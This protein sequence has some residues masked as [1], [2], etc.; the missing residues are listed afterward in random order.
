MLGLDNQRVRAGPGAKVLLTVEPGAAN[1]SC[2]VVL[3]P[4][5]DLLSL[6]VMNQR[7]RSMD[8]GFTGKVAVVTGGS[9]GIGLATARQLARGG[10]KVAIAYKSR[11]EAAAAAVAE[12]RSLG[13]EAIC[14]PCDV[15]RQKQVDEFLNQTR[16]QLGPVDYLAHCGAIS[17][18][19]THEEL[20]FER[21]S[22]TIDCNLH[23]AFRM[24]WGVKDEMLQRNSGSIV[25]ISSVAA[26]RP[27]ANQIHYAT[28]KA[29]VIALARCC[30]EAFAPHH[31]RVNCVAPGLI[32]TEMAHVLS[33]AQISRI[34]EATP[35]GRLG[36]PEEVAELVC[37][38]LGDRSSFTT[39]QCVVACGGRVTLP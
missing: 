28:A 39:G 24:V 21:W 35:L 11:I 32:E 12:L 29:G 26:L 14:A 5:E 4:R 16:A 9:R 6:L 20:T 18:T 7:S 30:A 33:E 36:K 23:G 27:R 1:G 37:F 2:S 8:D 13:A 34:I 31:V 19:A 25:L 38:L 15:S 3:R 22:E 17:N 10:A